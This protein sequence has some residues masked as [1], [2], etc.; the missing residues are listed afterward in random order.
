M[1]KINLVHLARAD[2]Y[3]KYLKTDVK[4]SIAS[5]HL[6]NLKIPFDQ[7]FCKNNWNFKIFEDELSPLTFKFTL[8][9]S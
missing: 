8:L 7:N 1:K 9:T 2:E 5:R 3:R 4:F 6:M